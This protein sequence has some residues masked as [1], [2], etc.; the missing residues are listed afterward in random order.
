MIAGQLKS[1][2]SPTLANRSLPDM[3]SSPSPLARRRMSRSKTLPRIPRA[4]HRTQL[5]LDGLSMGTEKIA[6]LRRWILSLVTVN[7]DLEV[8]PKITSIYPPL[9][10]THAEAQNIAFSSFP[11][12]S[13]FEEGSQTHSFRIRSRGL[14]EGEDWDVDA[15]RPTTVDG[16]IYGFSCFTRTK[17]ALSKRGYQQTS[18]VILSHLA[19]PSLFDTLVCRLAPSFMSHGGPML[20]AAC[21]NIAN[22]PDPIP[23][24]ALELGFLG[25]VLHVEL[26]QAIETQQAMSAMAPGRTRETDIQI[27]ASI[28][29]PD[30]PIIGL[31][32]AVVSNLWSIW[33][34]VVLSEPILVFGPSPSMSS[35]AV[36]WLRDLLRP[37]PLSGDFRPF[38]TIH[39]ADHTALV[40]PRPPQAGLLV[41]VTNPFFD[42]ACRHWPNVLS[43]GR[44]PTTQEKKNGSHGPLVV[45]PPPGWRSTHR[46][47]TSRDR[48]LLK[49]LETAC[50]GS[51]QAKRE[52]SE[53]L[54]QHLTSRTNALLV[55]LQRYLQT[56]IPTPSE[57][58]SNLSV[59]ARL[60]AF[61]DA[62]FF[63]SLKA[64][65][66][67]LPFKS[68]SKQ[69]EFYER[70]LRTPAF[71]LWLAR[72][73]EVVQGVL[74]GMM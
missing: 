28:C 57:S 8:G 69:R 2:S 46:R 24:T 14:V 25:A 3:D 4:A 43:L 58:R 35:R 20:E 34:C 48:T 19:Y 26:P 49:Q 32:E 59:P 73:E 38:F 64:H 22:W 36:W 66:S 74:N 21:H 50:R 54:R 18:I 56:L 16:F 1:S 13:Q 40:N 6:K 45:G 11:D 30:P 70:W 61:Q 44:Q 63:A 55:P 33:E 41:G 5:S 27:L 67:P 65:G 60:K 31:F 9:R 51:E 23:G 15:V 68:S 42:K 29:P 47:Y 7:F 52:A 39:D 10:L 17:D 72:Q 53:A 62:A 37:I 71:G 12:S